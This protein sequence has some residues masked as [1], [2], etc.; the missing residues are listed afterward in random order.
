MRFLVWNSSEQLWSLNISK[1][2]VFLSHFTM[3]LKAHE[4]FYVIFFQNI[5]FFFTFFCLSECLK[6]F[7]YSKFWR[8]SWIF[9]KK[10]LHGFEFKPLWMENVKIPNG[11]TSFLCFFELSSHKSHTLCGFSFILRKYECVF[12]DIEPSFL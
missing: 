2:S 12:F 6:L 8:K 7:Y 9:L 4:R 3:F 10:W 11:N 1:F 5:Y